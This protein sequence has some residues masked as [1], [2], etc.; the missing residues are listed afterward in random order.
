M[1][2]MKRNLSLVFINNHF[3]QGNPRPNVP[4]FIEIGGIQVKQ[5]PS[6]LPKDL[7]TI[8]DNASIGVIYFSMGTNVKSTDLTQENLSAFKNV[9]KQLKQ[10]IIWKYEND[11]IE[12]L[13]SNVYISKWLPQDDILAHKNL[14]LFIT[15][16]GLG[17]MVE[18]RYHGVPILGIPVYGDQIANIDIAVHEGWA[19]KLDYANLNEDTLKAGI[20]EIL[21][22]STYV[23]KIKYLS[24][25]YRDRPISALDN[26]VFWTEYVIRHRGAK[27]LQSNSVH[28]NFFQLHSIDVIGFL[29]FILLFISVINIWILKFCWRR[30]VRKVTNH[31]KVE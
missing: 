16:G 25:I 18:C 14:K 29:V 23:E 8:M 5:K 15:H 28:L 24:S 20:D 2:E 27:H 30:I 26:A 17:S 19:Y 7:Q 6:P 11:S 9:F 1:S 4:A 10:Q 12:N 13:P 3:S 21:N 31:S 22:N